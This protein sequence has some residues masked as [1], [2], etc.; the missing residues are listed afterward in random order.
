MLMTLWIMTVASVAAMAAALAGRASV[1]AARNRV[2]LSRASWRATGCA[3]RAQAAMDGA[4]DQ[5]PTPETAA[6]MWRV[7]DRVLADAPLLAACD[8]TLEAAGTRLD[9]N[10]AT[11]EMV[12]S[13]AASLGYSND[14]FAMT[15]A[16]LAWRETPFADARQL[17]NVHGF[18][19][20]ARFDSLVSVEPGRVS[21]AT[22][23]ATVLAT[24]PG[25]T[26]ETAAAIVARRTDGTPIADLSEAF[27]GLSET[28]A[29][30]LTARYADAARLTTPDPDAW[31]L[32]VSARS[33]FPPNVATL[34]WRIGRIGRRVVVLQVRILS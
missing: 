1:D 13:L 29:A 6:A 16:F 26:E 18:E 23:S 12:A 21:L 19:D 31:L 11:D 32:R 25:I 4:L 7:L 33:G 8:V 20:F 5:T 28:S 24:V 34:Q 15:E 9:L 22:A 14:A 30:A 17:A 10:S 27:A 2:E 3:R